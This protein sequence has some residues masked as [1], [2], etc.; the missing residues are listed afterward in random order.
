[1]KTKK[2]PTKLK[3]P[4]IRSKA[5]VRASWPSMIQPIKSSRQEF[6]VALRLR[7]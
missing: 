1:M 5:A 4:Q 2:K 3:Q 7:L 6:K